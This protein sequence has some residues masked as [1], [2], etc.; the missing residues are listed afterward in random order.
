MALQ[1]KMKQNRFRTAR[2]DFIER[3]GSP[4][5][6]GGDSGSDKGTH[7]PIQDMPST[8]TLLVK[9]RCV[10]LILNWPVALQ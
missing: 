3:S 4:K 10:L 6:G 7:E 1:N 9:V 8:L 5:A 2:Y